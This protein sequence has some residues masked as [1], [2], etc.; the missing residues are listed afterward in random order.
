MAVKIRGLPYQ[1]RYEQITEFFKD[2][3]FIEK[4]AILGVGADGRKNGFG[5]I[6]FEDPDEAQMAAKEL[7]GQY[8]GDRYVEISM[9]SYGDYLRFNGPV[10]GGFNSGNTV[11]L[12]KFVGPDNQERSLIMRG[13]PY[14]IQTVDIIDFFGG[15]GGVDDKT[16]FVEEFNG[17]RTGSALVIFD[18]E[19]NAKVAKEKFHKQPIGKE[20]RY[21]EL[22]DH[23]DQFMKKICNLFTE[24]DFE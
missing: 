17:K 19:E 18:T 13:L 7:D 22:Y 15:H 21:V 5:S 14:K 20:G 4:S 9:I 10:G 11:K 1:V 24:E 3:K 23:T 6:L 2:H 8:I 12:S 16:V